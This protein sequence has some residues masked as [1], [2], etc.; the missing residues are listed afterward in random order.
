VDAHVTTTAA[1][2]P[3][4]TTT[5]FFPKTTTLP[6]LDRRRLNKMTP[7]RCATTIANRATTSKTRVAIPIKIKTVVRLPK[8]EANRVNKTTASFVVVAVVVA[9][10]AMVN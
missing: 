4:W 1:L 8:V 7:A 2:E 5:S 9:D 10:A 3:T 6:H